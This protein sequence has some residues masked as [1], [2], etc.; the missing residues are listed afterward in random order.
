[1]KNYT[2]LQV[3]KLVNVMFSPSGRCKEEQECCTWSRRLAFC[4]WWQWRLRR[5]RIRGWRR[6]Q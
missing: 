2:S 5:S 3:R 6:W 4:R 1:M